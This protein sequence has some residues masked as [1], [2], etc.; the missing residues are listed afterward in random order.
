MKMKMK[1]MLTAAFTLATGV[2]NA[3]EWTYSGTDTSGTISHNETPWVLN[4]TASGTE[5][6][7][8]SV[9][10][11]ATLFS[12]LPLGDAVSGSYT[13][14][15]IASA[16]S[17]SGGVFYGSVSSDSGYFIRNLTLPPTLK[18]IG[19]YAFYYCRYLTGKLII[20]DSV[21]SI[22]NW[23]FAYCSGWSRCRG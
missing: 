11:R 4:V 3:G 18:T 21:T 10:T 12:A 17:Y 1:A 9:R 16:S 2:A 5:L 6:T 13:I 14:T 15:A 19:N 7:I 20:P 8:T 23:A 22:G